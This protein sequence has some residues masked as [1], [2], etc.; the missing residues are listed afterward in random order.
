M[1][2]RDGKLVKIAGHVWAVLYIFI[3][4]TTLGRWLEIYLSLLISFLC[5]SVILF[6]MH[7]V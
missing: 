3:F 1:V 6:S 5:N 7:L 2:F 4:T